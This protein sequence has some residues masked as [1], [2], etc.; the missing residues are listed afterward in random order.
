MKRMKN[1]FCVCM[2]I[3]Q[4]IKFRNFLS[5]Y[6]DQE[7]FA[8]LT[9]TNRQIIIIIRQIK[10]PNLLTSFSMYIADK[11]KHTGCRMTNICDLYMDNYSREKSENLSVS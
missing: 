9:E 6:M 4:M 5:Q 11:Y 1:A 3:F 2:L 7:I 10:Y 8:E